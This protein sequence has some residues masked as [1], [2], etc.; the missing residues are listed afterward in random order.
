MGTRVVVAFALTALV[1]QHVIA[2]RAGVVMAVEH[3]TSRQP[4]ARLVDGEWTAFAER[5]DC[6]A[7]V[8]A[9]RVFVGGAAVEVPRRLMAG[10]AEWEKLEPAIRTIV[11]Q[12]EREH[13][14]TAATLASAPMTIEW[15]YASGPE[16]PSITYYFEASRRVP[17]PGTAPPED[18]KGTLRVAVAGWLRADA[19]GVMAV[20]SRSELGWE[21]DQA[22]PA[23]SAPRPDL[24]P[25]GVV[26]EGGQ[27]VWVMRMRLG[28][29]DRFSLYAIGASATVRKLFDTAA[30]PCP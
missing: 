4:I 22:E 9:A 14:L 15:V 2:Q 21:Q 3:G 11:Q 23:S 27:I 30:A 10:T 8:S 17:D 20:G 16:R 7:P 24:E 1:A 19:A 6:T 18:P 29:I 12:R 5:V 28:R 26:M 25:L 13:R